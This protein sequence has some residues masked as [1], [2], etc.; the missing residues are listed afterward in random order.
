MNIKTL[1]NIILIG[2]PGSG[3]S[4]VGVQLAKHL[5]MDFIDTD[6]LIQKKQGETL[7][8]ILDNEGYLQLRQYEEE[9]LIAL[10]VQNTVIATG[11]SAVYSHAGMSHLKQNGLAIYLEVSLENLELR[12]KDEDQRGIARPP[13][14]Q[15]ID[16]YQERLPLYE[17]YADIRYDNNKVVDIGKLSQIIKA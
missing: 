17:R 6:L 1:S 13:G 14:H 3:K 8:T 7:Q 16:V 12:V 5:G 11:G 10:N 15:F 9:E 4:T 2:M